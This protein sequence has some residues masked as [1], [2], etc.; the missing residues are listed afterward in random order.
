MTK[1]KPCPF[2]GCSVHMDELEYRW[3]VCH[4]NILKIKWCPIE[5]LCMQ[6]WAE[7]KNL[8]KAIARWNKRA[9]T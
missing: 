2:C 8:K 9:K 3:C 5:V 7:P 1:L 6:E 4:D